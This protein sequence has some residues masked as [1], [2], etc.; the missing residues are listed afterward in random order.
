MNILLLIFIGISLSMDTFSLSL[1]LGTFNINKRKCILFSCIVAYFHFFMPLLGS[2]LGKSIER[3]LVVNPDKL[4]FI[5]FV[6][7]AI[8]MLV[9][10]MSKE[11]KKYDFSLLNMIMYAFSVSID[12]LTVGIGLKNIVTSP[13]VGALIFSFSS[14]GFTF[15]GLSIGKFS[16]EKLGKISKIIGLFLICILALIHLFK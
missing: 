11:D 14:F 12:S 5:I 4:L 3:F 8:E 6:F 9:E 16:Y 15:L 1:S 13:V 7:I 2:I 10:L